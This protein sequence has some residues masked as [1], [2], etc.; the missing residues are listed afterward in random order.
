[1]TAP[2]RATASARPSRHGLALGASG[3]VEDRPPE[4]DLT[5]DIPID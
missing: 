2:N 5:A 4:L 1:M 3:Y